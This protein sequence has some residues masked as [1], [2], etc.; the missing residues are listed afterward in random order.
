MNKVKL[1]LFTAISIATVFTFSCSSGN[2]DNNNSPSGSNPTYTYESLTYEGQTYNTVKIGSQ[3]WMAENLN[4]E[5]VSGNKCY[6]NDL[7]NCEEYG[8][9]YNWAT[10]MALDI[11]CNSTACSDRVQSKH[12]GICPE[13]WHIPSKDEWKQL[14][15]HVDN[16][17]NADFLPSSTAS[18]KLKAKNGWGQNDDGTDNYGFAALPGGNGRSNGDFGSVGECGLWLS[19]NEQNS[20]AVYF[21]RMCY[22]VSSSIPAPPGPIPAYDKKDLFSVRC[23]K[24]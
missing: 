19:S 10:A 15:R 21:S 4:Y 20:T 5:T 11:S 22:N 12:R 23:L 24:D 16:T 17:Y 6:N 14:Y 1:A 13:G 18:S 7:A 9:L 2:D 8:R 3:T